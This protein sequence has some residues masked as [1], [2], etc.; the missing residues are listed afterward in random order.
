MLC[1]ESYIK[2]INWSAI[3]FSDTRWNSARLEF[4]S[5]L[6]RL[7]H[8]CLA[9]RDLVRWQ[10]CNSASDVPCAF[11]RGCLKWRWHRGPGSVRRTYGSP[12]TRFLYI[13]FDILDHSLRYRIPAQCKAHRSGQGRTGCFLWVCCLSPSS[14]YSPGSKTAPATWA[15]SCFLSIWPSP[16][17]LARQSATDYRC[18]CF[19]A[20]SCFR[21]SHSWIQEMQAWV[22]VIAGSV[23]GLTAR[24]P[25]EATFEIS[26]RPATSEGFGADPLAPLATL[27][28]SPLAPSLHWTTRSWYPTSFCPAI[29]ETG[30]RCRAGVGSL[31]CPHRFLA[32]LVLFGPGWVCR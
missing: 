8:A 27:D 19:G 14:P 23:G 15:P 28:A 7:F 18:Y 20:Q 29:H 10:W 11:H 25:V 17:P 5:G 22:A 24:Y 12:P 21:T 16:T 13:L 31:G 6:Q 2:I 1:Q 4:V 30:C 26:W 9:H 32:C 3:R